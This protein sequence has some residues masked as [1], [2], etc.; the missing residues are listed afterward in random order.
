MIG[1]PKPTASLSSGLLA[2]KGQARPAMR[3]QGFLGITH[4]GGPDDL[5]WNDMGFDPHGANPPVAEAPAQPPVAPLVRPVVLRQ[6]EALDRQLLQPV[7]QPMAPPSEAAGEDAAPAQ[8]AATAL[9]APAATRVLSRNLVDRVVRDVRAKKGKAAFTLRLDTDRHL[10][11]RLASA[12]TN[13]SAQQLVTEALD[14]FLGSLAE[15][16]T[17]ARQVDAGRNE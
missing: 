15:V 12:V 10:R 1:T 6:R 2:R 16:E 7:S 14:T 8:I 13:R 11:L 3:P 4:A 17:L 5:G 9:A